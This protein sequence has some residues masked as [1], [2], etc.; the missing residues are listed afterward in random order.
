MCDIYRDETYHPNLCYVWPMFYCI[1]HKSKEPEISEEDWYSSPQ[2]QWLNEVSRVNLQFNAKT[3]HF[4]AAPY[5]SVMYYGNNHGSWVE[6][7]AKLEFSGK[8][9]CVVHFGEKK[10]T[11][12]KL[13]QAITFQYQ[14]MT[15]ASVSDG[16][17]FAASDNMLWLEGENLNANI[18]VTFETR[19]QHMMDGYTF[20]DDE[21]KDT[22]HFLQAT[23]WR[24]FFNL[25]TYETHF[26]LSLP[27]KPLSASMT[28]QTNGIY[29][30]TQI[31]NKASS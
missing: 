1:Y 19:L 13:Y 14:N 2:Y 6:F 5:L 23:E 30:C 12:Q 21:T 18:F 16:I 3:P 7:I 10:S 29:W 15:D 26:C 17:K 24:G 20:P 28:L 11:E 31:I 27:G 9:D 22:Y 8:D 25:S 4:E